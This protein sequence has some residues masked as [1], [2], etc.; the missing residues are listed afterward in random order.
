[1][2][3]TPIRDF[4]VFS[5]KPTNVTTPACS[6]SKK[7]KI[8]SNRR[9]ISR[10]G[11]ISTMPFLRKSSGDSIIPK[12]HTNFLSCRPTFSAGL[13]TISRQSHPAH[14]R[15]SRQ[16]RRQTGSQESGRR[17]LH[18]HVHRRLHRQEYS[19]QIARKQNAETCCQASYSR[20]S[21]RLRFIS[22]RRVSI[23]AR[24]ASRLV[25]QSRS[26]KISDWSQSGF[27]SSPW[28]RMETHHNPAQTHFAPK[29]FRRGH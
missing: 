28:R 9:T 3:S 14:R 13:R 24:L 29:H 7:K 4:S 5:A 21:V 19:R 15:P 23:P 6:I 17:L 25:C 12:V 16:S 26:Q 20:S 10:L 27:V 2:A 8:A 22:D 11:S 18:A 1:M